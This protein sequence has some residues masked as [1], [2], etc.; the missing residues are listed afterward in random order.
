MSN[1]YKK[2]IYFEG[3]KK[4]LEIKYEEDVAKINASPEY[5]NEQKDHLIDYLQKDYA[6]VKSVIEN[7]KNITD[8]KEHINNNSFSGNRFITKQELQE[9]FAR[10]ERY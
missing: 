4:L 3:L 8:L 2:E 6:D 1:N 10:N 5:S 7:I 9:M